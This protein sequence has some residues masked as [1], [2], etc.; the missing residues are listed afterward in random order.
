MQPK[1]IS[2]DKLCIIGLSGDGT[3]TG[4]I[5]N[6]FDNRFKENPFPKADENGYEIRFWNEAMKGKD[7]HV[8][9]LTDSEQVDGFDTIVVP[10]TEY[11]VFEVLVVNGYDSGNAEMDKWLADNSMLLKCL[12]IDGNGFIIRWR[13][14]VNG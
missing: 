4:E 5:W 6:D 14:H 9:F 7:V 1:I 12:E 10:A 2:R 13:G 3:K 8:G 11:A